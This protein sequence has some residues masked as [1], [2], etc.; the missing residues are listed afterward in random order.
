MIT[1]VSIV[2]GAPLVRG[3]FAEWAGLRNANSETNNLSN[4]DA[5]SG[6]GKRLQCSHQLPQGLLFAES[7]GVSEYEDHV[8]QGR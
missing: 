5:T 3:I 8:G 6:D 4:G 2:R 7:E 1:I